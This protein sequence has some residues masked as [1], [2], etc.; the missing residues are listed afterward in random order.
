MNEIFQFVFLRDDFVVWKG[1]LH[2]MLCYLCVNETCDNEHLEIFFKLLSLNFNLK[3][4]YITFILKFGC[5]SSK[6]SD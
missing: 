5:E 6:T 4:L 2:F 1:I 3:Q